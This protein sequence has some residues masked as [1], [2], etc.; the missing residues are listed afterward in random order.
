MVA[1][2]SAAGGVVNVVGGLTGQ[3]AGSQQI[4]FAIQG[5]TSDPKFIPDVKGMAGSMVSSQ[6]GNL[7]AAPNRRAS[8]AV[9]SGAR[10]EAFSARKSK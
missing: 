1:T 3:R 5:T 4:P 6:V 8:P 7:W 9:E 10:W 2:L